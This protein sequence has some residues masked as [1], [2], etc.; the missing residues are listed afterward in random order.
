MNHLLRA[1][2]WAVTL[3]TLLVAPMLALQVEQEPEQEPPA[4]N[5]LSD[6]KLEALAGQIEALQ[7]QV[8]EI[9]LSAAKECADEV[10]KTMAARPVAGGNIT[11]L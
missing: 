4:P 11:G 9:Q 3:S 6:E 5:N 1:C 10:P 8:N 2:W 7:Q